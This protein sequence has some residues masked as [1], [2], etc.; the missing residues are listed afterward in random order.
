MRL[1]KKRF[2][3]IP[4]NLSSEIENL[5]IEDLES[6]AEDFLDFNELSDLSSWLDDRK[7]S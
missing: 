1:L 4:T 7:S 3:E 2:V 6:L 5:S